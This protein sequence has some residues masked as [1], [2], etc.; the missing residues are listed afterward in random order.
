MPQKQPC[1]IPKLA[2]TF[3]EAA[4]A[5]GFD[6]AIIRAAAGR[7]E[8]ITR[9]ADGAS[10]IRI[11]DLE[12]W[13]SSLPASKGGRPT[14]QQTSKPIFRT[15]EE[16]AP[17]LGITKTSL[18]SYC[19]LSGICTRGSRNKIM[20]HEDDVPRLVEWIRNHREAEME[21]ANTEIDHFGSDTRKH[22][23]REK[24]YFS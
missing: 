15:P 6:A 18:R 20:I 16:V 10:V 14:E 5:A 2:Y 24:D 19:R 7:G 23:L 9:F 11:Q 21:W 13:L 8:L 22:V 17:E 3:Q 4:E 1:P 12:D